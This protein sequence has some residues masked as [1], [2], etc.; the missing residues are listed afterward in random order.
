M[1][2]IVS[3]GLK[4]A[5]EWVLRHHRHHD[6]IQG[7]KFSIAAVRDGAVV[8][9]AINGRPTAR[10]IDHQRVMEITRLCV[11]EGQRN[12][13]SALLSASARAS[14]E[15]GYQKIQTYIQEGESGVSL[16]AAGWPS[17]GATRGPALEAHER[18]AQEHA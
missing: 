6:P 3:I 5:N 2:E 8:G 18:P 13:C 14:K 9:V 15:M 17:R 7:H 12:V 4:S 16:R 11:P 1:I 10:A